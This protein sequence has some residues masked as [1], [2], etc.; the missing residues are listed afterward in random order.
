MDDIVGYGF[1]PTD[2]ELVKFYLKHKLLDD[3][4]C[5]HFI[6]DVDLCEVEPWDLPCNLNTKHYSMHL[7]VT[8]I[9]QCC[10]ILF[11]FQIVLLADSAVRFNGREWFFFSPVD[12]KYSNSKRVNRTTKCGFWKPTG[13][14]RGIRSKD[15]NNV[16]GTKKTLVYYQGR[17]SSGVKSN[18][19]IHEYHAVTFHE[20]QRTFVLCR[21]MKKPGKTT[22]GGTDALICDEGG[23]SRSMV[24]DY[25]N[26]ATT[27]GIPSGGTFTGMET[28]FQGMHLAE[29]YFS[30]TQQ[31]PTGIEQEEPSFTNYPFNNAYFRN[32][33]NFMQT[34]FETKE[35]DAFL[36]SIFVDE[37]LVINEE[38]MHAFVN[39][40][41]QSES[42]RRVYCESSDTDAEVVSE[43]DDN[44]VDV[45]TMCNEY[46]NSDGYY[47]SER[48][49]SSH[50]AVQDSLCLLSTNHEANQETM[51]SIL[52]N[53]FWG[54]EQSY[55]DSTANKP[56][57]INY[58]EI[59]SSPSTRRRWI[60]Q[61]HPRPD[62]FT[63]QKTDEDLR[64]R[65]RFQTMQYRM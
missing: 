21:L 58:T 57:E 10:L 18:W 28:T 17:V 59:S 36:N 53:N 16:I 65:G 48:F 49:E 43:R 25:E 42:L 19:V 44:I 55:C 64:H 30:P 63:S 15:T 39:S 46:P 7:H 24:S 41:T 37:N 52:Q 1:R 51:E 35:E 40:S 26:Q 56:L 13:K 9:L 6:L 38:S 23:P 31:S 27:Q 11:L 2:E 60:N 54:M 62:Y 20:S 45:S 4:P 34:P 3:D 61:Y 33:D 32:E 47:S 29:K 14:D 5:V 8:F 12:Y 50:G 22:E